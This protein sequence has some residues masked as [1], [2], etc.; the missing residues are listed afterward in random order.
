MPKTQETGTYR[1]NKHVL[2][3]KVNVNEFH[4][5]CHA[6]KKIESFSI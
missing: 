6:R 3:I 4:T 1:V 2:I 5:I